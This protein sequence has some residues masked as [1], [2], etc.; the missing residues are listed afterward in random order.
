[1]IAFVLVFACS[2]RKPRQ[3]ST[4]MVDPLFE[5]EDALG[6]LLNNINE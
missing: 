5:A 1:M 2:V 4:S 3:N 6:Y